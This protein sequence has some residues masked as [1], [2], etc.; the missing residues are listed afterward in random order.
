M[1]M[2]TSDAAH[3]LRRAGFGGTP[4]EIATFAALD[5]AAAVER[6][7]NAAGSPPARPPILDDTTKGD[8]ERLLALIQDWI[9][10]MATSSSPLEEKMTFFWHGH[11]VSGY[12]KT[13]S[14]SQMY[15]Q[16]AFYRANALGDFRALTQGMAIQVAMLRYL[17]GDSN[18][19]GRPNQNFARELLELFTLGI[20]N[21]AESDV[22]E[23]A[24]AWTGYNVSDDG[25]AFQFRPTRHDTGTKT[26]FGIAKNWD[27][28]M[29]IDEIL[30]GSKQATM[31]R[32]I[33]GKVWSFFAHPNPPA[34]AVDAMAQ[35]FVAGGLQI[36]PL[37]RTMFLRDE[38]YSATAKQGL[39]RT[40]VEL[41]VTAVRALGVP[42][43]EL[44]LQWHLSNQGHEPFNPPNV[45]GWKQN[46]Y[47]ISTSEV[48]ARAAFA[49][50]VL[51]RA[52]DQRLLPDFTRKALDAAVQSAF[53]TFSV[54]SPSPASKA[55]LTAWLDGVRKATDYFGD[56]NYDLL[57]LVLMSPDL[58][59][60]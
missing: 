51:D 44:D 12:V 2:P 40:P 57:F 52:N 1:P 8:Y 43:T 26:I 34:A 18:S 37:L 21:Y 53:E 35:A 58:V 56:P 42:T 54:P 24:R 50:H 33:A 22:I 15:D 48:A 36:R 3:L 55:A 5:R 59:V 39:V 32:Y 14:I 6:L 27:G 31:A 9:S 13:D 4:S 25:S 49:S 10:R 17:D 38:F 29:E 46:G 19:K 7:V 41:A 11:F 16:I 20:G 28:P 47:W 60:A 23:G 45:A 30:L